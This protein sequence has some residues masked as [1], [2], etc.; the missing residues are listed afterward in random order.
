[1]AG[2]SFVTSAASMFVAGRDIMGAAVREGYV[3]AYGGLVRLVAS[4]MRNG[5]ISSDK[6]RI[7]FKHGRLTRGRERHAARIRRRRNRH[8]AAGLVRRSRCRLH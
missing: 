3:P 8:F 6:R 5:A 7:L 1:M 2:R 4:G